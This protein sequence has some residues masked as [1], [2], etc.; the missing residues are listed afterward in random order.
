MMQQVMNEKSLV[1]MYLNFKQKIIASGYAHEIDWQNE[2]KIN[3][4]DEVE[5]IKEFA[6]VILSSGMREII[7]RRLFPMITDAFCNWNIKSIV[8][9]KRQCINDAMNVFA[10]NKKINAI[11]QIAENIHKIGFEIFKSNIIESDITFIQTLPFM[12][13][14]TS[15]HLAK[16]IGLDVVKPDR[17]LVRIAQKTGYDCPDKMCRTISKYVGDKKCV[18]DIVIWRFAALQ[19]NYLDML[20]QSCH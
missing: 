6:W 3:S 11:I 4:L 18:V 8:C 12:G 19:S 15:Y 10:N 7:I 9:N 2:K 16:N 17:H 13:P 20:T 14:A 1:T 5:L